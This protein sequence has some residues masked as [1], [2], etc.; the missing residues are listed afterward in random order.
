MLRETRITLKRTGEKRLRFNILD[1]FGV[2][3]GEIVEI[4][5][6]VP[7]DKYNNHYFLSCITLWGTDGRKE[8]YDTSC[9]QNIDYFKFL[10][11]ECLFLN[12]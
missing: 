9:S 2:L 6:I 4:V 10:L 1:P 11:I 3:H 5:R 8:K 12:P 7:S